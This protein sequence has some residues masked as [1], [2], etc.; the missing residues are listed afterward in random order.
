[1][2]KK[3]L[4]TGSTGFIGSNLVKRLASKGHHIVS[5][6]NDFRGNKSRLQNISSNIELN[7]FDIR[8]KEKLL[9]ISKECDY[10]IHLAYINGTENFYSKP[11]EVLDVG[12]RG[13]LNIFDCC[14]KNKIKNLFIASS[15]EVLHEPKIIPT[16]ET[17]PIIIPDISNPRYSYAGGKIMYEL[18]GKHLAKDD[19]ERIVIFRPFNVY[20]RDM[21]M[22]HVIPQLINRIKS[23][24]FHNIEKDENKKINFE[25]QGDGS[26]TRAFEHI[27]D[28]IDGLE[29]LL[30]KGVNREIYNI[31]NDEEISISQL[32]KKI[33]KIINQNISVNL[34]TSEAPKGGT[35]RRCPDISKLKLL[36]YK[37]NILI[38]D[39]LPEVIDFYLN[40]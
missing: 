35:N 31:G 36:G 25:I 7:D 27:D 1:M 23:N 9:E 15:S 8:D 32:I 4:I 20:G 28:F 6:D 40:H 3:I 19:I 39:G 11:D 38:D 24:N 26:Q 17:S 12:I 21:G 34:I 37:P 16:N 29:I 18:L 30:D 14:I 22:G 10:A 5:L 13:M 2:S 33:F